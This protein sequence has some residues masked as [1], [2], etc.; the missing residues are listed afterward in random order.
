MLDGFAGMTKDGGKSWTRFAGEGRGWDFGS[1]DWTA[2]DP[3]DLIA[4]HHESGGEIFRSGN[5]G[6]SWTMV[7]KDNGYVAVGLFDP[8]TL[9]VGKNGDGIQRSTDNGKTWAK[10]ANFSITSHVME[11]H[12]GV[13]F[14]IAKEG[15]VASKDH[16]ATWSACGAAV[17][18]TFGPLFADPSHLVVWNGKSIFESLDAGA[19]WTAVAPMPEGFKPRPDL[20]WNPPWYVNVGWDRAAGILYASYMGSPAYRWSP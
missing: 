16:G 13:G 14:L 4:L 2:K 18:A 15:L 19:S 3:V 6:S 10:V 17:D 8:S 9:I 7:A 5:A 1:V 12:G 20:G 11:V